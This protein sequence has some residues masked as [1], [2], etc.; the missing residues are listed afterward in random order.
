V[1]HLGGAKGAIAPGGKFIG[2]A[3]FVPIYL[4][5]IIII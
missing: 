2:A 4:L 5:K 3:V 1:A